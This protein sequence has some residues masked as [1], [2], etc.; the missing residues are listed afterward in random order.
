LISVVR[1]TVSAW[2]NKD[3]DFPATRR[4]GPLV[5]VNRLEF[6]NYVAAKRADRRGKKRWA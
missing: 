6:L 3:P 1:G 5:L 4:F 2:A